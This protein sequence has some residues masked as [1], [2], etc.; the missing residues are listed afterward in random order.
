MPIERFIA[1]AI[2]WV[3][4]V[5][6]APTTVPA[7]I[8]ASLS[9]TKPSNATAR[10][11]N[12]LYSEITTGM[13]APPIGSVIIRPNS[14]ASAKNAAINGI[15]RCPATSHAPQ[16]DRG[17]QHQQVDHPLPGE[18][19]ALVQPALQLGE[20]DQRAGEAHRADQRAEHRQHQ[21]RRTG[22]GRADR[23]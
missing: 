23:R 14:S 18:H 22:R 21:L 8:I 16:I 2:S 19:E 13:S 20:G 15:V 5:P 10:P 1:L 12:A 11:V 17:R 9:S 7:M 6:A 4:N 3:S